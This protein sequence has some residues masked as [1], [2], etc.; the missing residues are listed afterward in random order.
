MT[1]TSQPGTVSVIGIGNM[2]SA[3]AKALLVTEFAVTVWNRTVSKAERLVLQGA[4]LGY[5]HCR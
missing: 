4:F 1:N 5:Q 3:L 2:G